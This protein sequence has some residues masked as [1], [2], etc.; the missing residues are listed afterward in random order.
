MLSKTVMSLS[1]LIPN[2]SG[3][4]RLVPTISPGNLFDLKQQAKAPVKN[5]T[6]KICFMK[7]MVQL[8][9]LIHLSCNGI[10]HSF[11]NT[12]FFKNHKSCQEKWQYVNKN[13]K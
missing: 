7:L 8:T 5:K 4:P 1:H 6:Y 13:H 9:V 12:N 10:F 2:R 3:L 11:Y